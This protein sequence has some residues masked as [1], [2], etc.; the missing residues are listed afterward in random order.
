MLGSE[1]EKRVRLRF[2]VYFLKGMLSVEQEKETIIQNK[3][4]VMKYWKTKEREFHGG[5]IIACPPIREKENKSP[6]FL[7]KYFSI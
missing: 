6:L 2:Q 7:Y 1:T 4:I 3:Y 5:G